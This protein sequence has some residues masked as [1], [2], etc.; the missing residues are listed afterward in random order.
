MCLTRVDISYG[1]IHDGSKDNA[2]V[3]V[4]FGAMSIRLLTY[5]GRA[6]R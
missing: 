6:D 3:E 5:S 1:Q 4:M 2:M